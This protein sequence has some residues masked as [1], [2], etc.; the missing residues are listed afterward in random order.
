MSGIVFGAVAPHPPLLVP[1]VGRGQEIAV[2]ATSQA[3]MT[4]AKDLEAA[5]PDTILLISPHGPSHL[6]AMGVFYGPGSWG[7]FAEWGAPGPDYFFGNDIDLAL[8][9]KA[10]AKALKVPLRGIGGDS[11]ELD[12]GV[13]V[14]MFFL[15]EAAPQTPVVQ[16]T[17]SLLPLDTHLLFGQALRRAAERTGKRVAIIASGDLSHRLIPTAPAGYDPLGAVFDQK[18]AQ[19]VRAADARAI[20]ALDPSLIARAGQC[21]LRSI[22][23]LLGALEGLPA[24]PQVLSYEGP[25]GVGYL[26]ASIPVSETTAA[27]PQPETER[28]QKERH[29]PLVELAMK[30]VHSCVLGEAGPQ[31]EKL[32]PEMTHRAGVFVCIKEDGVLRGCIG[33]FEPTRANVAEEIVANSLCSALQDPRFPPVSPQELPHLSYTVDVLSSPEPIPDLAGHDPKKFGLMVEAAGHRGLLLPNLD[34]VETAQQQLNICLVKAGIHPE[35]PV[36]LY[37]FQVHRYE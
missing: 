5:H 28:P 22:A 20:L 34:G 4:L 26:V 15:Q 18:I 8:A 36:K 35:E 30:A 19:I 1:Q 2:K 32:T 27:R 29:H 6:G 33:T 31:P 14:P 23:V 24:R 3:M 37:R 9:I 7:N 16:L 10:Q 12:H 21:G 13:M 11:Y 25:F 17:F